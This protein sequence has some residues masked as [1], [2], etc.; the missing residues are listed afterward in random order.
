MS[1][2]TL[3]AEFT[4]DER[5]NSVIGRLE[6]L[7]VPSA[8]ISKSSTADRIEVTARVEDR[9]IEKASEILKS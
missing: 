1:E 7:G 2:Q 6:V 3:T 4:N 8:N 5:A 9:L